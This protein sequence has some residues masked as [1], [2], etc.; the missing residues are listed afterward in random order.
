ME[1]VGPTLYKV[2]LMFCVCWISIVNKKEPLNQ[3]LTPP[4]QTPTLSLVDVGKAGDM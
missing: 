3:R 2:I 4:Y 1:D